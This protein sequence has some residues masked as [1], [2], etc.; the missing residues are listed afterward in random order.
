M[1]Q[2]LNEKGI[3]ALKEEYERLQNQIVGESLSSTEIQNLIQVGKFDMLSKVIKD[4]EELL[5]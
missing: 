2:A 1:Q 4:L 5:K 3:L